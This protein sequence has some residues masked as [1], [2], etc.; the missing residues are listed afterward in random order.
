HIPRD[1]HTLASATQQSPIPTVRRKPR[2]ARR[3]LA[4]S[5]RQRL[6]ATPARPFRPG[7]PDIASLP[8]D[9]WSRLTAKHW[10]RAADQLYAH[11]DSRGFRGAE[12]GCHSGETPGTENDL[13]DT[14]FSMSSR[15]HDDPRKTF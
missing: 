14:V 12:F 7:L 1:V 9:L 5:F 4:H 2:I 15:L 10:Q 11:A 13:R 8:L 3:A 6:A